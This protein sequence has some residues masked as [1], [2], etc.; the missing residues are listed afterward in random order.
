MSLLFALAMPDLGHFATCFADSPGLLSNLAEIPIAITGSWVKDGHRFSITKEDLDDIVKNF[1]G[2]ANGTVVIDYEHASE[3]PEVAKGDAV[4]ASGWIHN[5]SVKHDQEDDKDTLWASVEWTPRAKEMIEG[6]EYRFFSPAIDWGAAD[7]KTGRGKGATLTS[8]ALTN[9]PFLEELPAIQLSDTA[10]KPVGKTL[11]VPVID[12]AKIKVKIDSKHDD[13]DTENKTS[14]A[15]VSFDQTRSAVN[16]AIREKYRNNLSYPDLCCDYFWVRELYDAYAIIDAN[17]KMFKIPY[18]MG[19]DQDVT[20]GEPQEV[21]TEYV[22]ASE[23]KLA[24]TASKSEVD[25]DHPSSHYLV[26]EDPEK[27][28]TWHLRVKDKSGKND[29]GLMGGAWAALHGGYRGSKYSGPGKSAALTKLKALYKSEGMKT[30]DEQK[31]ESSEVTTVKMN[32]A[33]FSE[34]VLKAVGLTEKFEKATKSKAICADIRK[35]ATPDSTGKVS[36]KTL[37]SLTLRLLDDMDAYGVDGDRGEQDDL[38]KEAEKRASAIDTPHD[39]DE[40]ETLTT[41]PSDADTDD[42]DDDDSPSAAVPRFTIR[43]MRAEDKVGKMNHHAV[44]GK[45]GK[46]AGYIT[47]ANMRAHARKMGMKAEEAGRSEGTLKA[48]ELVAAEI[49]QATGR[50]LTM[51]EV[52]KF[53]ERG[54]TASNTEAKANAHKLMLSAAVLDTG[55]ISERAVRRLLADEKVSQRDYADFADAFEDVNAAIMEGKLLPTQRASSIRMC[56]SDREGFEEFIKH[57]PKSD[58]MQFTGIGGTGQESADPDKELQERITQAQK[59]AGG[60]EKLPY[61][62]AYTRVLASDVNLAQRYKAAHS[63][64][65]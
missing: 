39:G 32:D 47:N 43:K 40:T 37:T 51:S 53:V 24:E 44:I 64:L 30:P 25:G 27:S 9:H 38:R 55:S 57:Q 19:K 1:D 11:V 35:A 15:D 60:P 46:L 65:M 61:R 18:T 4:P 36:M 17:G 20:L 16:E 48:S 14:L 54:I 49:K 62:D 2:R 28:T 63:R 34:A 31:E 21:V 23:K 7:K 5:L 33:Q 50:P 41:K 8:G 26:V 10:A 59:D 42:D 52:T 13:K 6:G 29:H 12:N 56:L 58:R 22:A 45:D 3:R